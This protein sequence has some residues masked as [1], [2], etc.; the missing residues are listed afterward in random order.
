MNKIKKTTIRPAMN[1]KTLDPSKVGF[2]PFSAD[3]KT[4]PEALKDIGVSF[5]GKAETVDNRKGLNAYRAALLALEYGERV[6][7]FVA[8]A[9]NDKRMSEAFDATEKARADYAEDQTAYRNARIAADSIGKRL[10]SIILASNIEIAST[11]DGLLRLI[12][13]GDSDALK[14]LTEKSTAAH[15]DG[16]KE[17]ADIY[18]AAVRDMKTAKD[19]AEKTRARL[20]ACLKD[21]SAANGAFVAGTEFWKK[22]NG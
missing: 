12:A 8:L 19:E 15:I 3:G 22:L 9:L 7:A 20:S 10:T 13:D 4:I 16:A 1:D 18:A 2:L 17:C 5:N 11:M 21:E 6:T 14:L